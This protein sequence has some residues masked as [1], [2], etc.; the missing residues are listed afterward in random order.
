MFES[1]QISTIEL[2]ITV[3]HNLTLFIEFVGKIL[4]KKGEEDVG[5]L[6]SLHGGGVVKQ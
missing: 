4:R 5:N 3:F 2:F 6:I 1:S